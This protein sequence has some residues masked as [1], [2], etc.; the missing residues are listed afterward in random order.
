MFEIIVQQDDLHREVW[1]FYVSDYYHVR[2][3]QHM[4]Q[5]R[6][7]KRHRIWHNTAQWEQNRP[8]V[9]AYPIVPPA[10]IVELKSKLKALIDT[11]KYNNFEV[12]L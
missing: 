12:S 4:I 7:T 2:L 10:V 1:R 8:K 11:I 3:W 5:T 6:E 9:T